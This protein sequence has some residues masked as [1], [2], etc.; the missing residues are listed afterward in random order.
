MIK[1]YDRYGVFFVEEGEI[2]L[3]GYL[4]VYVYEKLKGD[5]QCILFIDYSFKVCKYS[6][7]NVVQV[8]FI[9]IFIFRDGMIFFILIFFRVRGGVIFCEGLYIQ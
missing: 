4:V 1:F 9:N 2:M 5:K 7:I 8:L 6:I 3:E